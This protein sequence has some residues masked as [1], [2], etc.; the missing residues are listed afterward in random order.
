[1]RN[2]IYLNNEKSELYPEGFGAVIRP[3]QPIALADELVTILN[4]N[5]DLLAQH[6]VV[7]IEREMVTD[8]VSDEIYESPRFFQAA[9]GLAASL[10][11]VH[12]GHNIVAMPDQSKVPTIFTTRRIQNE[13]LIR[14]ARSTTGQVAIESFQALGRLYGE[15]PVSN[16][17]DADLVAPIRKQIISAL[18]TGMFAGLVEKLS[19]QEVNIAINELNREERLH[20]PMSAMMAA[21]CAPAIQEAQQAVTDNL[22]ELDWER[23]YACKF[24]AWLPHSRDLRESTLRPKKLMAYREQKEEN[25]QA[26]NMMMG[27]QDA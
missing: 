1:M 14:F 5:T 8:A 12:G 10:M 17:P 20:G 19:I 9:T 22:L 23:F 2:T 21:L 4:D 11:H 6:G 24:S 3:S 16:G 18:P 27:F 13:I 26:L 7:L 15:L 25:R